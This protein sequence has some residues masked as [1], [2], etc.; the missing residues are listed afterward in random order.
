L[1]EKY[2]EI[3]NAVDML[4]AAVD[5][6]PKREWQEHERN[7]RDSVEFMDKLYQVYAAAYK[8]VGDNIVL[9]TERFYETS[10]LEPFDSKDFRDAIILQE[11]GTLTI[12]YAPENQTYREMLLY[13]RWMPVYTSPNERYL[14]VAGVSQYSVTVS[15]SLWVSIGQWVS[16]AITFL[17][18]AWLIILLI[19]LGYIYEQRGENKWRR[20]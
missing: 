7:I 18:N 19:R 2:E 9:I 5:A 3:I 16:M 4:E 8:P 20:C 15:I 1:K 10:P 6:N 14:V 12:G 13:F 17:L 11:K